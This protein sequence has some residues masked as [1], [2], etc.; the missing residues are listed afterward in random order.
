[1]FTLVSHT[2][3]IMHC[4]RRRKG[5]VSFLVNFLKAL[6]NCEIIDILQRTGF[7]FCFIIHSSLFI[8]WAQLYLY[9][10]AEPKKCHYHSNFLLKSL[11]F[12]RVCSGQHGGKTLPWLQCCH[13]RYPVPSGGESGSGRVTG[14]ACAS[15]RLA[16]STKDSTQHKL[17]F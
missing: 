14:S 17:V 9:W 12:R 8:H 5:N 16:S 3:R 2:Q 6:G 7:P 1:M 4:G 10:S 15:G 11:I 13:I